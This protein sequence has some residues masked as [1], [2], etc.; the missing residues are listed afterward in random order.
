MPSARVVA[1]T[2]ANRG[3]PIDTRRANFK[4]RKIVGIV[5]AT[6][7]RSNRLHVNPDL[8]GCANDPPAVV[9]PEV[10]SVQARDDSVVRHVLALWRTASFNFSDIK[11]YLASLA[12]NCEKPLYSQSVSVS[13]LLHPGAFEADLGKVVDVEKVRPSKM[14][15]S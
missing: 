10:E 2:T 9:D 15:I 8:Y 11:H 7:L 13:S 4:S 6:E 1:A 3:S 14:S 12:A 5:V